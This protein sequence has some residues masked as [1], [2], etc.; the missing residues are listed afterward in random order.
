MTACTATATQFLCTH[1]D[2]NGQGKAVSCSA[3]DE[4]GALVVGAYNVYEYRRVAVWRS[5]TGSSQVGRSETSIRCG[6]AVGVETIQLGS[7][8]ASKIAV[9]PVD[10]L[11]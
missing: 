9:L 8:T 6:T 4:V 3:C 2:V 11:Q 10:V 7:T 1:S 5:Q